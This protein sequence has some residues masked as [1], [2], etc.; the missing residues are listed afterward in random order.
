MILIFGRDAFSE[1]SIGG[2]ESR[3]KSVDEFFGDHER[4][5]I[6]FRAVTEEVSETKVSEPII[7][8]RCS[9]FRHFSYILKQAIKADVIYCHTLGYAFRILPLMLFKKVIVDF[10]GAGPEEALELKGSKVRAGILTFLEFLVCR[11]AYRSVLISEQL[12]A[13]FYRKYGLGR[14][15]VFIIP[16]L[17]AP[18]EEGEEEKSRRY[19]IYSGSLHKWQMIDEMLEAICQTRC[20]LPVMILTGE[21]EE[22]RIR[23][24]S[25]GRQ[26]IDV[27]CVPREELAGYYRQALLGFILRQDS[28]VNG[29]ACPTKLVE[30]IDNGIVPITYSKRIGDF[31][32]IHSIDLESYKEGVLPSETDLARMCY[33]NR[34]MLRDLYDHAQQHSIRLQQCISRL[35]EKDVSSSR[36]LL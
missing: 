28:V 1:S 20:M 16:I 34:S 15:K 30:Y 13:L 17:P 22:M 25:I 9:F 31:K 24:A 33:H 35:V 18:R 6:D 19:V 27:R 26:D 7:A 14:D 3:I 8:V 29:V 4:I 2:V 23:L 36:R 10:H 12:Y 11:L 32:E 21:P 5:Y